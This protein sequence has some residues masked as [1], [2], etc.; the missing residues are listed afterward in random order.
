MNLY[1]I[2]GI[3]KYN[4]YHRIDDCD[5]RNDKFPIQM[6]LKFTMYQF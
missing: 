3:N 6:L 1:L 2:R 5:Q 4:I